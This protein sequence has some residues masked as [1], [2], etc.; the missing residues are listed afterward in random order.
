AGWSRVRAHLDRHAG[1]AI[2]AG[3]LHGC[4]PPEQLARIVFTAMEGGCLSW[5][6]APEGSLVDRLTADLE[7]LLSGWTTT[8]GTPEPRRG[9]R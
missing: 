2:A 4:P 8:T 6:V 7:A 1:Q 9:P 3:E 5:S